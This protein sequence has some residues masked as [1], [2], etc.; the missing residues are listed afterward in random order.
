MKINTNKVL[1]LLLAT[2]CFLVVVLGVLIKQFGH[3]QRVNPPLSKPEKQ[4]CNEFGLISHWKL[5]D[6]QGLSTPDS[7][8][9][10]NTGTIKYFFINNKFF[11]KI[12]FGSPRKIQGVNGNALHFN[13]KHWISGGNN[14][15][16]NVDKFTVSLWVWL[17]N[18]DNIPTML[19]KSS[20]SGY[21]GW[22]L[23]TTHKT[24][25]I[26]LGIGWGYQ[27]GHIK[28][29]YKLPLHEWHFV[30]VTA[31]NSKHE[32]QFYIDGKPYGA[33]HT[34]V[35]KWLINWN[36]DL[37]LAEYDGGG[38]WPWPGKLDDVRFYSTILDDKAIA[39]IYSSASK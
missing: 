4:A 28:S 33:K 35:H 29:G 3:Y 26:D 11:S 23:C 34:N 2:C 24:G 10:G 18:Y 12:L 39:D 30:A 27:F 5:D 9:N 31:D 6:I 16:Y 14:S 20:F 19:A 38:Y 1:I 36:H 15:C 8:G 25:F 21:D 32:V 22:W 7:S 37:F 17:D 13:G